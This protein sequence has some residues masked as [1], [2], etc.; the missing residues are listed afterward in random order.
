MHDE[1]T[2]DCDDVKGRRQLLLLVDD[3]DDLREVAALVLDEEGYDVIQ[4]ID[5]Q[6][7]LELLGGLE[8]LPHVIV[9]DRRMPL[10]GGEALIEALR[11]QERLAVLPLVIW[12]ATPGD[13]ASF[14]DIPV[15]S[16][17]E[18]ISALVDAVR[19]AKPKAPRDERADAVSAT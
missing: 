11:T 12:S 3:D 10:M 18:R 8:T 19:A 4:A 15:I 17:T 6:S 16:K 9:C 1:P 5:G 2:D 14:A 13:S 7:A